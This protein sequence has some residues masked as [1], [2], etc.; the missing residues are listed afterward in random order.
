MEQ[1]TLWRDMHLF[2]WGRND[3]R[4]RQEM[5]TVFMELLEIVQLLTFENILTFPQIVKQF[6]HDS[7]I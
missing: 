1:I 7:P 6:G 4:G 2:K 5:N 3:A